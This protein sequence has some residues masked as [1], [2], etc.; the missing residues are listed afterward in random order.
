MKNNW[1]IRS[2]IARFFLVFLLHC[3]SKV[4]THNVERLCLRNGVLD[5]FVPSPTPHCFWV[6]ELQR[7]GLSTRWAPH[8]VL[9]V[10]AWFHNHYSVRL[11][12]RPGRAELS[13]RNPDF[14]SCEFFVRMEKSWILSTQNMNIGRTGKKIWDTFVAVLHDLLRK[15]IDICLPVALQWI[16]FAWKLCKICSS[17]ILP[18]GYIYIW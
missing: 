17:I 11:N 18:S 10:R 2:L 8:F 6:G 13:P 3:D 1:I 12:G 15:G 14:T 16:L 7:N 5:N 4:H 9:P